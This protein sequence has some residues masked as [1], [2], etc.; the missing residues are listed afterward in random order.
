LLL[1]AGNAIGQ[2]HGGILRMHGR[3]KQ[4]GGRQ[5]ARHAEIGREAMSQSNHHYVAV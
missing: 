1:K 3:H 5:G 4:H 2:A